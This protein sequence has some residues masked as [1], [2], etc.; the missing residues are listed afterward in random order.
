MIHVDRLGSRET[1]T[2]YLGV[3]LRFIDNYRSVS[4]RSASLGV[5]LP[6]GFAFPA[7]PWG[8]SIG[9]S[10]PSRAQ[11][12]ILATWPDGSVKWLHVVFLEVAYSGESSRLT[13]APM[14]VGSLEEQVEV[15]PSV[16]R[17]LQDQGA[18]TIETS[19]GRF[20]VACHDDRIFSE[21]S[22]GDAGWLDSSGCRLMCTDVKGGRWPSQVESLRIR[23]SGPLRAVVVVSGRLGRRT[24]LRF[25]ASLTFH[26]LS[27]LIRVQTTVKNPR[28][29]RH[30]GGYWDLGDP[31]SLFLRDLSLEF[32]IPAPAERKIEWIEEVEKRPVASQGDFLE[33]YQDS[34][35]GRN[36]QSRNHINRDGEIPL[37][38]RGYRVRSQERESYGLRASPVAKIR[39]GDKY[40]SCALEEFWQKFPSALEVQGQRSLMRLSWNRPTCMKSR[41]V[42]TILESLGSSS[43][44]A[45]MSRG[46]ACL[47]CTIL[48]S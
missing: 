23:E 5:P 18:V 28:R 8:V 39:W 6:I 19:S 46:E 40:V 1:P 16:L 30:S 14:S 38:F 12:R 20:R 36:W 27:N 48:Q 21:V 25:T 24:G 34:S 29:A 37:S 22:S 43:E 31:G 17:V 10:P 33:I 44:K 47:G 45:A 32:S 26:A 41:R 3:P 15:S 35:G 42:S 13:L 11:T 4:G 7:T 2:E 9:G